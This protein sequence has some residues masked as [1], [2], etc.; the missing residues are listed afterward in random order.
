[1]VKSK[2]IVATIALLLF[3]A[4]KSTQPARPLEYY[5]KTDEKAVVSTINVPLNI[6][7]A[8]LEKSINSQLGDVLFEDG[9]LAGDGL[10]LRATRH[11]DI[12]ISM[13]SQMINYAVPIDLWIKKDLTIANVVAEGSLELTFQTAYQI[14]PDWSLT[15]KTELTDYH[16]IEE[17][18]IN[19][20]FANLPITSIA[21]SFLKKSKA[22]IAAAIDEQVAGFLDLRSQMETVWRELHKPVLVS[23]DY[24]AWLSL[25][26]QSIGM[27]PLASSESLVQSTV[28][29]HSSPTITLGEKPAMT[30][31]GAMPD[32]KYASG[33]GDEFLVNIR[34]EIPFAGAERISRETMVG[35]VFD[36]G[37][38]KVVVEDI[39]I[40]GQGNRLVVNT[41]LSGDYNGN[42][43][44][45]G[46]PKYNNRKNQIELEKVDF[47][48][49]SK[50]A[51]LKTASWLFKGAFKKRVQE[52]LNYY[53]T[54]NLEDTQNYIRQELK[55][56]PLAP[57]IRLSGDL[58]ELNV[59]HVYITNRAIRVEIG[60]QGRLNV[61]VKSLG[62]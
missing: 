13:D 4:C 54:Y 40:Y 2:I 49:N 17:P 52:S 9:N 3:Q 7:K 5:E 48:F 30:A 6:Y 37:K 50:K 45:T 8:E 55:D 34:T 10:M 61:E 41:K 12:R 1:M 32:F 60:L 19:L 39:E 42:V 20:G 44:F 46:K 28:V 27:T 23:E 25:N 56:Y 21:N 58:Y 38:K 36:Y 16:W 51:L 57:G 47:D 59:S 18:M 33:E 26:P 14:L 53:L 31:V 62:F 43:Y 24:A 11:E 22:E 29:I 15:T 35:E